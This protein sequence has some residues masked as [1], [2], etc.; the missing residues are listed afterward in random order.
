LTDPIRPA[1]GISVFGVLGV[2]LAVAPWTAVWDEG[3]FFLLST[4]AA[5]VRSG[6]FRGTVSGLGILDLA[7]ALREAVCLFRTL[8]RRDGD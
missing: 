8:G 6:W 2:F 7:V 4:S 5:W 3:T 1:L